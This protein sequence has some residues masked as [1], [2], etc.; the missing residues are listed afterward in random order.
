MVSVPTCVKA[1]IGERG[2]EKTDYRNT[3]VV[4]P[5]IV[6]TDLDVLICKAI[7]GLPA[8]ADDVGRLEEEHWGNGEAQRLRGLQVDDQLES[9]GLLH[10]EV[11][12]LGTFEN[13]I[14]VG[15]RT[16]EECRQAGAVGQEASRGREFPHVGDH[17]YP[18]GEGKVRNLAAVRNRQGLA[19]RDQHVGA[20]LGQGG[21]GAG[22][23]GR[24]VHLHGAQRHAQGVRRDLHRAP[25]EH[26][27]RIGRIPQH[28]HL[29]GLRQEG[30]EEVEPIAR[31]LRGKPGDPGDIA[32][33]PRQTADEAGADGIGTDRHDDRDGA[34][35]GL[36]RA[37]PGIPREDHED[38]HR[39]L[40]QLNG[41][42]RQAVETPLR[43]PILQEAVVALAPAQLVQPVAEGVDGLRVRRRSSAAEDPDPR[44]R[45]RRLRLESQGRQEE[46]EGEEKPEGAA[47]HG[48]LRH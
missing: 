14:H 18:V 48:S 6:S 3:W 20:R 33:G 34:R 36:G 21:E 9:H 38:I 24:S 1:E 13:L 7:N 19:Q 46:S 26:L 42:G 2:S 4:Y 23:V 12:G 11:C 16:A 39:E 41:E 40:D 30:F 5:R 31:D 22:E 28:R 35:R 47:H 45:S 44:A 10:R 29:R 43:P 32:A 17:R 8:S 37:D 25:F 27:L 15:R